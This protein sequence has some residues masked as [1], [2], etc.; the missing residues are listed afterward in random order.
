MALVGTFGHLSKRRTIG[1]D[2]VAVI[3]T[4]TLM[5]ANQVFST[6]EDFVWLKPDVTIGRAADLLTA[7]K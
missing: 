5:R 3:N 7:L 6:N 1:R 4:S 2:A